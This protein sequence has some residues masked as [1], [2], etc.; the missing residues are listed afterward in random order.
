MPLLSLCWWRYD[1]SMQR[2]STGHMLFVIGAGLVS[3]A[4]CAA[5]GVTLVQV[6]NYSLGS[7]LS[8]GVALEQFAIFALG[9]GYCD[10]ARRSGCRFPAVSPQ[11]VTTRS[12]KTAWPSRPDFRTMP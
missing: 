3:L 1:F 5:I 10:L 8:V 4:V 9:G 2:G 6:S 7:T 11:Q 12:S